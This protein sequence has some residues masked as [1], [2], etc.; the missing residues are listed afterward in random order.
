M[1]CSHPIFLIKE[2]ISLC[3]VLF[4]N[5]IWTMHY[6]KAFYQT[7]TIYIFRERESERKRGGAKKTPFAEDG[8]H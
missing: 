4:L 5:E 7:H 1:A 8:N 2:K 3:C 6:F